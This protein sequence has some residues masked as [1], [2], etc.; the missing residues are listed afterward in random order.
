M[1]IQATEMKMLWVKYQ[2][3]VMI[4]YL[5]NLWVSGQWTIPW[6]IVGGSTM[7]HL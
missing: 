2:V 1:R 3:V 6:T 5:G 4:K 7:N